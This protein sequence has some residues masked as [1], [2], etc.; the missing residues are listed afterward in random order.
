MLNVAEAG[1]S[2]ASWGIL[3]TSRHDS[4]RPRF[5]AGTDVHG[6]VFAV[7]VLHTGN[8]KLTVVVAPAY[9]SYTEEL[10][11]KGRLLDVPSQ[12]SS[13]NL[14]VVGSYGDGFTSNTLNGPAF[15]QCSICFV[16][17]ED[18]SSNSIRNTVTGNNFQSC[19]ANTTRELGACQYLVSYTNHITRAR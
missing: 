14:R 15:A 6:S 5:K 12:L 2:Q 3:T 11:L 18:I 7:F 17:V 4:D 1:K 8:F 9:F 16:D 10:R 19:C 13:R